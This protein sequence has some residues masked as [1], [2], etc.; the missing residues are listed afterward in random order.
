MELQVTT[1][2]FDKQFFQTLSNFSKIDLKIND[3]EDLTSPILKTEYGTLNS[4][5]AIAKYLCSLSP[6][7]NQLLGKNSFENAI[8]DQWI[9]MSQNAFLSFNTNSNTNNNNVSVVKKNRLTF[10]RYLDSYLQKNTFFGFERISLADIYISIPIADLFKNVLDEN[11]RRGLRSLVRWYLTCANNST[12]KNVLGEPI[13]YDKDNQVLSNENN[14]NNNNNNNNNNDSNNKN[15]QITSESDISNNNDDDDNSNDSNKKDRDAKKKEKA[16]VKAAKAAKAKEKAN[17]LKQ[18]NQENEK[19]A[20][21]NKDQHEQKKIRLKTEFINTTIAGEKKDLSQPMAASYDPPAVE[22]AWYEWWLKS[23]FFAPEINN[24]AREQFVIVIPPP[25]VTGSLHLGHALTNSIQDTLAR[26][27]RMNGRRVLWVPGTDHA[28]IA[29]QA[30]VE[31]KL[32]REAKQ[33][34]HDLGREKFVE[35]VWEWKNAYGDQI[36]NQLKRLGS[37]LDWNREVFTMD[38]KLS[39]AVCEAFIRLYNEKLIYRDTRLVNWCCKLK[40]AISDI[41]VD[42]LVL[43]GKTM[44]SI[45]GYGDNKYEFGVLVLFAYKIVDSNE[46][47]VVAT[48]RIETMLGDTAIAVHPDDTRYKHLHGKFALHPFI[49]RKIPII[50]DAELVDMS[51]GTGAVKITPAHDPNDFKCGKKHKLEFITIFDDDGFIN[52]NGGPFKGLKRF[53][54]RVKVIEELKAKGL[55]KETKDNQ[56]TLALCSRSKDIIEPMLKPQWWVNCKG[57]AAQSVAAVREGELK[58]IPEQ[59]KDT[60]YRWLENIHDWCISRQLWWG[61]RI[62]AYLIEIDGQIQNENDSNNWIVA[63]N[64]EEALNIANTRFGTDK[65]IKLHQDPDVLDT[66]F[67]SGLFPFSVFGWPDETEDFKKFYPTS[68]LETGNDILFFW[69]ARMVM[70]GLKLTGKLPFT[71]VFLH[72][73]VRDAHGRKMSKSLG[74]VIDPID[75]TE[76]II[77]EALH[78]K[79]EDG[80][81]DPR[82]V[83]KARLGQKKDF[84]NGISECGTDALRFALCAYTSQGR[85]INLEVNRI[86]AYRNFCNKIWNATKFSLMTLGNDFIP[87]EQIQKIVSGSYADQWILSKLNNAIK[88]ANEAIYNYEFGQATT[89]IYNFWLYH[90]CDVYLEIIKP[91]IRDTSA[92]NEQRKKNTKET[93]YTCVEIGLRL[94]HP[95]MPFVTEELWQRIPRR[96][97]EK[98]PSICVASYPTEVNEWNNLEIENEE[99]IVSLA[100]HSL[101]HIQAKYGLPPKA[102]IKAIIKASD[103][104][105]FEIFNKWCS[106]I[107][108]LAKAAEITIIPEQGQPP[109]CCAI[110]IVNDK[111]ATYVILQGIIDIPTE[112]KK[113]ENK[114]KTIN[115]SIENLKKQM[116]S[117]TYSKVP[118]KIQQQNS[119]K[120]ESLTKELE[121]TRNSIQLFNDIH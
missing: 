115:G 79:L 18:K 52:S 37:S 78:K 72:S 10:L 59:F 49:D 12:I 97:S 119:E 114:S 5:I 2:G 70:L 57:M 105:T 121:A 118:E 9:G 73:M 3:I 25:N 77:L 26:W 15:V 39:K 19:K 30:V 11:Y 81:L 96:L 61:H 33:T 86:V 107:T 99:N 102:N 54:A 69:V 56:M 64:E 36:I 88:T 32:L 85:D 66:W 68:L 80:N 45:P 106:S 8:V 38:Q 112:I 50:A 117:P 98:S 28:G 53:D 44:L 100:I 35:K 31:K 82:E 16:A 21:E 104:T 34:R 51:F 67:S 89:A 13:F 1:R 4:T 83:E 74:N 40:T 92:E 24:E 93:L 58:I 63:H 17:L 84:P 90:F 62:P 91:I 120:L 42:H 7:N 75:V 76:G 47:I 110:D 108:V 23:G 116:N 111:I 109:S 48:T 71:T 95:F 6:I 113:L 65:K 46:E 29:T 27:H 22:A 87:T 41:E 103:N 94:L 55:Y 43:E 101:R 14:S 60:W 20:Q